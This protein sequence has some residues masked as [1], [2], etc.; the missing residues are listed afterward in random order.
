MY[1]IWKDKNKLKP[2]V[3]VYG[4]WSPPIFCFKFHYDEPAIFDSIIRTEIR[5]TEQKLRSQ[6]RNWT[7]RTE[8]TKLEPKLN[9]QNRN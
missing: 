7:N 9:Q 5:P 6:N 3:D 4:G 2:K 1:L 8:I